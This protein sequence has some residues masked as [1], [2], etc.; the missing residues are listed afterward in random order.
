M[1]LTKLQTVGKESLEFLYGIADD[2][3]SITLKPGVAFCFRQ[4]YGIVRDL[5]R[6]AW[7]AFVRRQNTSALGTVTELT[8][9]LF[10]G[11]R[12]SLEGF[13]PILRDL[14]R[15]ACLYCRRELKRSAEIDHFVPWSRYPADIGEN[16]VLAHKRCNQAKSNHLAAEEHL[17][18]WI[19]RNLDHALDFGARLREADL[20]T[21]RPTV[22]HVAT[23]AYDQMERAQGQL[24]VTGRELRRIT[25]RWREMLCA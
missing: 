7:L 9:F 25:S 5:V 12:A 8:E 16:L 21:D 3:R 23:W 10:P 14:Q 6:G 15:G 2:R 11:A 22:T 17:E 13:A 19:R 20:P 18:A 1:P 4:F 24:W